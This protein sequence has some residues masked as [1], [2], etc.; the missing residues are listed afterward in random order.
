MKL[1]A[2]MTPRSPRHYH[3]TTVKHRPFSVKGIHMPE[4]QVNLSQCVDSE[5][6]ALKKSSNSIS[7]PPDRYIN[8]AY[9][10]IS[11][12]QELYVEFFGTFIP[13]FVSVVTS[14]ILLVTF[15]VTFFDQH[16]WTSLANDKTWN[17]HWYVAVF[18]VILAYVVGAIIYRTEPNRPDKIA[19]Y[20]QWKRSSSGERMKLAVQYPSPTL[21]DNTM[22]ADSEQKANT[23]AYSII[24][25]DFNGLASNIN[26]RGL[27]RCFEWLYFHMFKNHLIEAQGVDASFPYPNLR[28]YLIRRGLSH[29]A[30]FVPWCAKNKTLD[31]RTKVV[32]NILKTRIRATYVYPIIQDIVRNEGHI[33]LMTSIWHVALYLRR[34]ACFFLLL[35]VLWGYHI[36]KD[37]GEQGTSVPKYLKSATKVVDITTEPHLYNFFNP[38]VLIEYIK[39]KNYESTNSESERLKRGLFLFD[40]LHMKMV[41]EIDATWLIFI[42]G[43]VIICA[44]LAKVAIEKSIH[45]VRNREVVMILESAYTI[46]RMG[47]IYSKLFA[48]IHTRNVEFVKTCNQN[49][50]AT[51]QIK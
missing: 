38:N 21:D 39:I 6:G 36:S 19:S 47:G 45:Y 28:E 15:V 26:L 49:G 40:T 51:C 42:C 48:D 1:I 30:E 11:L 25:R 9:K 35:A 24:K 5:E 44:T 46:E 8:E 23:T 7:E 29:L 3:W 27:K 33:R 22:Q 50:C 41:G 13:G 16:P 31:H 14:G 20:K 34:F 4:N 12:L 10:K 43:I 2:E 17:M 32:I 37:H 18:I